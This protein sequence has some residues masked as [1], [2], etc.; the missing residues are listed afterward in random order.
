MFKVNNKDTR[1]MPGWSED[2]MDAFWTSIYVLMSFAARFLKSVGPFYDIAGKG[3][4]YLFV[5]QFIWINGNNEIYTHKS[6]C[7]PVIKYSMFNPLVPSV[8]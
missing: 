2:E 1:T 5:K 4:N 7:P 8:H 6:Q 3:L